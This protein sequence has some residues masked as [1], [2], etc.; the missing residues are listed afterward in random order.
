MQ[1]RLKLLGQT[2]DIF[3]WGGGLPRE[4]VVAKKFCMSLETH[5]KHILGFRVGYS[6]DDR[7]LIRKFSIDPYA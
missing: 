1:H 5:G 7:S 2:L 4:G 3:G 6:V